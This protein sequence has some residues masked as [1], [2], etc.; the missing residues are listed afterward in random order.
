MPDPNYIARLLISQVPEAIRKS[1]G[2]AE[3]ND[4][5]VEAARLSVQ[6]RDPAFVRRRVSGRKLC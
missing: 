1:I 4:R 3:L 5:L 2:P 6:A